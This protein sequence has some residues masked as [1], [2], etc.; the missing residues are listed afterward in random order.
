MKLCW[1]TKQYSKMN[2]V[3]MLSDGDVSS[4]RL[5]AAADSQKAKSR[6]RCS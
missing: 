4:S 6:R 5:A 1:L 2:D 3:G